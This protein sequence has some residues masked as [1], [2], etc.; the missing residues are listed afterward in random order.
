[1]SVARQRVVVPTPGAW[2]LAGG[3]VIIFLS[4]NWCSAQRPARPR[5]GALAAANEVSDF[6][7]TL[8][9]ATRVGLQV[10]REDG[11]I[12]QISFPED[13]S[14]L[15][16]IAKA[17]P[18]Y[19]RPGM[20]VRLETTLGPAGQPMAPVNK[21]ELFTPVDLQRIKGQTAINYKPGVN[22]GDRQPVNQG[23]LTGPVVVVGQLAGLTPDGV[24]SV[25]AGQM[26]VQLQLAADTTFEIRAHDLSLAQPGDPVKVLGFYEPPNELL[27]RGDQIVI[28]V[29]RI[30]GETP[31][32]PE[33]PVRRTRQSRREAMAAETPP[34]E[35][36]PAAAEV[37][38]ADAD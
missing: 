19:L 14:Q 34:A 8:K 4:Q 5:G 38:E 10:K 36:A 37:P 23:P 3:L 24:I 30:Y 29:D 2:I 12:A 6:S 33:R 9:A 22:P 21:V 20:P 25:R 28:R 11:Q 27:I 18:A 26:P 7:G 31:P 13:P 32:A 15:I 1:M 17:L 16:F 35:D